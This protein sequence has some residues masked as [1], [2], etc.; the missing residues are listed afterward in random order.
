MLEAE[1]WFKEKIKDLISVQYQAVGGY[2]DGTMMGGDEQAGTYKFPKIGRLESY[3]I[4]SAIQNVGGGEAALEMLSVAP[5]DYEASAWL[6]KEDIY[7]MG[8]AAQGALAQLLTMAIKRRRDTIKLEAL[9]TFTAAT[10]TQDIGGSSTLID[11]LLL[12]QGRAEIAATGA[13]DMHLGSVFCPVMEK[14]M[15]QLCQYKEWNDAR[16]IGNDNLPW[17]R[18]MRMRAKT[19]N[20]VNYFTMPDEM[21]TTDDAGTSYIT[22]MWAQ[23]AMGAET[24]WNQEAPEFQKIFEK[25]GSKWLGKVGLGGAALGIQR[26]G[27]KKL[28]FK[29]QTTIDRIAILTEAVSP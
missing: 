16:F 5:K 25:E 7:K 9:N 21:F 1:K 24:P 23:S 19:I 3:E 29:K 22:H 2:L 17:A 12:E 8:P 4:T 14:W 6:G 18:S 13:D 15:S 10:D 28:R 26:Q 20:G 27:V 11:P